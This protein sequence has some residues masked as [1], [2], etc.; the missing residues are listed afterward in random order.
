M[1]VQIHVFIGVFK[2]VMNF[3][4]KKLWNAICCCCFLWSD[5]VFP[6]V[7]GILLLAS[8][9]RHVPTPLHVQVDPSLQNYSRLSSFSQR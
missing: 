2:S 3:G 7:N 1:Y 5:T 6:V 9:Y 4:K 8:L